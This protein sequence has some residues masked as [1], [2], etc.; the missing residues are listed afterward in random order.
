M[1]GLRNE[2]ILSKLLIGI[3]LIALIYSFAKYG[4][5]VWF[6]PDD[7]MKLDEEKKKNSPH[8]LRFFINST[9]VLQDLWIAR[10]VY[11]VI[12]AIVLF[13]VGLIFIKSL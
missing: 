5:L 3:C 13:S 7:F 9:T 4:Y 6:H 12:C 8:W 11:L 2:D 1:F 10:I